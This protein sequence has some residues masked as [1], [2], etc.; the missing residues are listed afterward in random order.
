MYEETNYNQLSSSTCNEL[1]NYI[2][3]RVEE[4]NCSI[5]SPP[6]RE[7]EVSLAAFTGQ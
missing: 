3:D 4:V 2:I 6:F 7:R 1:T 5:H